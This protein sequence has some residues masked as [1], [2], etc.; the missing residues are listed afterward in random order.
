VR[1]P[2][3]KHFEPLPNFGQQSIA[4]GMAVKVIDGL[5]AIEIENTDCQA[6]RTDFSARELLIQ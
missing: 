3:A 6:L 2:A 5:E 1:I 4:D